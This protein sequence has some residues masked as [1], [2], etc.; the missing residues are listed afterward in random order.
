M[1]L[2]NA[3]RKEFNLEEINRGTLIY[4]KH[5]SW[6][7][8]QTG[9]VTDASGDMVRVQYLPSIQNVLNHF[10]IP[11]IEAEAGEWEVRYSGDLENIVSFP[12]K[13]PEPGGEGTEKPGEDKEPGDPEEDKEPEGPGN[14][15]GDKYPAE[16]EIPESTENPGDTEDS[17]GRSDDSNGFER[18][19]V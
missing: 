7:K 3:E 13:K 14:P 6:P 9:I 17:E 12:E 1:L 2:V 10:F 16:P 5:K 18:P 15:G 11:A 4:A 19:V 8:G